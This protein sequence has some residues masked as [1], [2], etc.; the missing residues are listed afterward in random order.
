MNFQFEGRLLDGWAPGIA[1]GLALE[2]TF[3]HSAS[4]RW[5][6]HGADP[7]TGHDYPIVASSG[8]LAHRDYVIKV[9]RFHALVNVEGV[10]VRVTTFA[11]SLKAAS[12]TLDA[13]RAL[14][15]PS[16]NPDKEKI[17]VAFWTYSPHGPRTI[18][19][20]L[21]A[22]LWSEIAPNYTDATLER[23]GKLF[24]S[25]FVPGH[26]GQFV[27]WHGVPGTGKTTALRSL[28]REWREWCSFHYIADPDQFFG[29]H[30]DYMLDVLLRDDGIDQPSDFDDDEEERGDED[31]WRVLIL[32]DT[33]ELLH[34]D[35]KEKYGQALSR[36]LNCV[37]GMIG[38]G[39]RVLVFVTTNEPLQKLHDAVTRPGRGALTV[40]FESFKAREAQRWLDEHGVAVDSMGPRTLAELYAEVEGF[41]ERAQST[42]AAVGFGVSPG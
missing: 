39:L 38:Q 28:A 10:Q 32:E 31:K 30:A 14:I 21:D 36:F 40:E 15:P 1:Q 33:G 6:S 13:I 8:G 23:L 34:A 4:D 12:D 41:E 22:P 20:D 11:N 29:M 9:D 24:S 7:S 16:E 5:V 37:D 3:L 18:Y 27:L 25:S 19:R 42:S 35:A 2:H 26:G 17:P